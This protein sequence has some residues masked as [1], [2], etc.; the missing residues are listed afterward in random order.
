VWLTSA[1]AAI[2]TLTGAGLLSAFGVI[3]RLV[4]G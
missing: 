3:G 2:V 1:L 4:V